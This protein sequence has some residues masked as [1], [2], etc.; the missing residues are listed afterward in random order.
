VHAGLPRQDWLTYDTPKYL[1]GT[2]HSLLSQFFV[3]LL[4]HPFRIV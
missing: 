4:P 3:L 2:L 1:L